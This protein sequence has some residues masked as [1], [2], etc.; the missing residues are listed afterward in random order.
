MMHVPYKGGGPAMLA[1]MSGEVALTIETSP[2]MIPH[3][4]GG[5]LTGI[6]VSSS[7]RS[8][9]LPDLPTLAESG[10]PGFDVTSWAGLVAPAGT[11][12]EVL[13]KLQQS[14]AKAM[15][16]PRLQAALD[17]DGAAPSFLP[18]EKFR[19]FNETELKRWGEVVRSAKVRAE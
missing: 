13:E 11:A 5:K 14:I 10:V 18:G 7:A 4:K 2:A 15:D 6:A 9:A 17:A 19:A 12:P 8:K 1:A 16:N 3:V